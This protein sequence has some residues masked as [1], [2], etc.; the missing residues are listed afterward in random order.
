MLVEKEAPDHVGAH[1]A[2]S[3][4]SELHGVTPP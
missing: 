4:E 3:D 2:E 1:P